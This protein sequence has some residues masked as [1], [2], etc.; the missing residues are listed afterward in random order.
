MLGRPTVFGIRPTPQ[1]PLPTPT[2]AEAA[3]IVQRHSTGKTPYNVRAA[4]GQANIQNIVRLI[5]QPEI[6]DLDI[7]FLSSQISRDDLHAYISHLPEFR[8]AYADITKVGQQMVDYLYSQ[9][10]Q[11]PIADRPQAYLNIYNMMENLLSH[12]SIPDYRTFRNSF[13][14]DFFN[15]VAKNI[16]LRCC[17]TRS[18]IDPNTLVMI[19]ESYLSNYR[20][21][22]SFEAK[23]I[24]KAIIDVKDFLEELIP[25]PIPYAP[26][27]SDIEYEKLLLD[28]TISLLEHNRFEKFEFQL[29]GFEIIVEPPMASGRDDAVAHIGLGNPETETHIQAYIDRYSGELFLS[30]EPTIRTEMLI[31]PHACA[32]IRRIVL[33]KAHDLLERE[34]EKRILS[35]PALPAEEI[36]GEEEEE[37]PSP[38]HIQQWVRE[39]VYVKALEQEVPTGK[40]ENTPATLNT[41]SESRIQLMQR[42]GSLKV[43]HLI[44]ALTRLVGEPKRTQ[45]SHYI[46]SLNGRSFPVPFHTNDSVSPKNIMDCMSAFSITPQ[47][48]IEALDQ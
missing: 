1:K 2:A 43:R 21:P 33:E 10:T 42:I 26:S 46:F 28:G 38:I 19:H 16:F 18:E 15:F 37:E 25:E 29:Y 30:F 11:I 13:L 24:A 6:V 14:I 34:E 36:S 7:L 44:R 23:E 31:P 32:E 20:E 4:L 27:D 35:L 40:I 12:V 47:E 45:G 41:S 48:L 39:H 17:D 8:K 5:T 22:F 9:I 3:R